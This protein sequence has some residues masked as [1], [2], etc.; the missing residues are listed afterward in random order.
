[1]ENQESTKIQREAGI[2][3]PEDEEWLPHSENKLKQPRQGRPTD[4]RVFGS[5]DSVFFTGSLLFDFFIVNISFFIVNYL[6]NDSIVLSAT[7]GKL[8]LLF[9]SSWLITSIFLNKF[10]RYKYPNIIAA[11]LSLARSTAATF[12]LIAV[13]VV[14]FSWHAFS[15]LQIFGSGL[16]MLILEVLFFSVFY[17][18]K[19]DLFF[20]KEK[21]SEQDETPKG[22]FSFSLTLADTL[23]FFLS[24]FLINYFKRNTFQLTEEYQNILLLLTG[25][26]LVSSLLTRKFLRTRFRNI[27][28]GLAPFFKSFILSFATMAVI[29]FAFRLFAYSRWQ[30]FGPLTLLLLFEIAF[31]YIYFTTRNKFLPDDIESV[32]EIKKVFRQE[33]LQEIKATDAFKERIR[34][35]ASVPKL[36][37]KYLKNFPEVYQFIKDHIQINEI[38]EGHVQIFNTHTIYNI[39]ALDSH[40]L[41]LFINLHPLNDFRRINKYFLEVHRS[42]FNGGYFVGNVDTIETHR[43]YFFRKYPALLAKIFYPFHF[44]FKR[45]FPKMPGLKEIYFAVTKGKNRVLSKAETLGRLYFSGFKVLAV[46]EINDRLYYIAQRVNTPSLDKN[47]SYSPVIKLERVG[48][49]GE[50]MSVYKF[51]T[52]HPYSEYLQQY[53]FENYSLQENGKFANDFRVTQ[54]GKV[55]RRMW[56]DE[57]PQLINFWRGDINLVGVRA[58]SQHYFSLYPDDLKKLRIRFKPGLIPPYYADMPNSFEEIIES[59]RNYLLQKQKKPLITDLKYFFKAFYNILFKK[60]RSR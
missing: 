47:P 53:I 20:I 24:F 26:W 59:E 31:Y 5:P 23:F 30:V 48:Y 37:D 6:K 51:R 55:F 60:A 33:T 16:L 56:I 43:K 12:Y 7:Y 9:N 45:V 49:G 27:Y 41:R 2:L 14:I 35:K 11:L 44:L 10:K 15:R 13:L 36:K 32:E 46:K 19:K 25:V 4:K 1:M 21:E 38:D 8:L 3:L 17:L 18:T 29:V 57:L 28:Y 54:W 58:L 39:E 40:C 50:I 42:I 22:S 34:G 52:M